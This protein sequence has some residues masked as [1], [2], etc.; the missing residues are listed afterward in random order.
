MP[1]KFEREIDE[2]LSKLDKFPKRGPGQRVRGRLGQRATGAQR[3]FALRLARLSVSQI[4]LGGIGLILFAYFFRSV[5]PGIWYYLVIFGLI[6]FFTSF[7]LSFFGGGRPTGGNRTY[8]RGKPVQSY[9]DG[10]PALA[11][12]LRDWWRRRQRPK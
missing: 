1:D 3:G 6:L 4:M 5:M 10:G 12:R 9:Y 11:I 2:I 7:A 8:W